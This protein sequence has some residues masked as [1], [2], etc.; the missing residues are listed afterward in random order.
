MAKVAIEE[1]VGCVANALRMA[2]RVL[3]QHYEDHL[4]PSGLSIGQFSILAALAQ[5]PRRSTGIPLG[6]L[7]ESLS[8]DR[9]TLSR[10]LNPLERDGLVTTDEGD[11][12]RTRLV[13]ITSVGRRR[14]RSA[15]QA[16]KKAQDETLSAL[17]SRGANGL[18]L[19]LSTIRTL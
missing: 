7:A 12:R 19:H 1:T 5:Q 14:L 11:D 16:W 6:A 13:R 8:L 9:T 4:R 15:L 17:G 18:M 3:T 10:N 2:S